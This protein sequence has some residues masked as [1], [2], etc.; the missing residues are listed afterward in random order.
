MFKRIR[1][2][3][4]P[5]GRLQANLLLCDCSSFCSS[6]LPLVLFLIM[7]KAR[8]GLF[9]VCFADTAVPAAKV[10]TPFFSVIAMAFPFFLIETNSF[11][12]LPSHQITLTP[13]PPPSPQEKD[14]KEGFRNV[15]ETPGIAPGGS[16]FLFP[17]PPLMI[18]FPF[19]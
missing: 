9:L 16:V 18:S 15:A 6:F 2:C 19:A 7:I 5:K 17:T 3:F 13:C 4:S 8:T 1:K 10:R 12:S 14:P 11:L